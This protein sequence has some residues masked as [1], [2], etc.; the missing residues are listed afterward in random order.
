M[1]VAGS[2]ASYVVLRRFLVSLLGNQ[3]QTSAN[4]PLPLA[5]G[6]VRAFD[7]VSFTIAGWD[8]REGAGSEGGQQISISVNPSWRSAWR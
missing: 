4:A 3:M 6:D 8:Y 2:I 5:S 1:F 7:E